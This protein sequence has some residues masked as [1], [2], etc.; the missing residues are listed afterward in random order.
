[1]YYTLVVAESVPMLFF[2]KNLREIVKANML[3]EG[4]TKEQSIKKVLLR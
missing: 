3:K 2:S 1:M 4:L